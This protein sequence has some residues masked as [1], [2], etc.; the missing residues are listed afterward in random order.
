MQI[1]VQLNFDSNL[2][3]Q[4]TL[5]RRTLAIQGICPLEQGEVLPHITIGNWE[6]RSIESCLNA[7]NTLPT[8][9]RFQIQLEGVGQ[10]PNQK[11][12]VFLFPAIT[13]DLT[14]IYQLIHSEF[15]KTSISIDPYYM[16]EKW[17]PHC[18][19]AFQ[20]TKQAMLE[21]TTILTDLSF[22]ILGVASFLVAI[23][24]ATGTELVKFIL[25]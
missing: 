23:D 1:T 16:P 12:S 24:K 6:F 14:Q 4:L 21:A 19:M 3:N 9:R 20:V 25:E 17:F 11:K 22:P 7:L 5:I 8:L 15:D 2:E 18:M 10:F 13:K